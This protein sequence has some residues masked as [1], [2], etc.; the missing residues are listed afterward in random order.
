VRFERVRI[1]EIYHEAHAGLGERLAELRGRLLC[2]RELGLV[3]Q[4][5]QPAHDG[6]E[7]YFALGHDLSL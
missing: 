2:L 7:G 5:P 1:R 4:F 6:D 3:L